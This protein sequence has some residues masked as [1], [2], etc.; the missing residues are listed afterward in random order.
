MGYLA[1]FLTGLMVTVLQVRYESKLLSRYAEYA[2]K[3]KFQDLSFLSSL[4]IDDNSALI[5]DKD[6]LLNKL[7]EKIDD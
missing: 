5:I 6:N 7:N 1:G 2:E 4:S 3:F